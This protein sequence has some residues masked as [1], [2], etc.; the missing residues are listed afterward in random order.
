MSNFG[1]AYNASQPIS[2]AN[3]KFPPE[4]PK[5]MPVFISYPQAGSTLID[6]TTETQMHRISQV[7]GLYIDNTDGPNLILVCDVT[8]QTIH[9]PS[10][11][12]GY[13]QLLTQNPPKFTLTADAA[14][15]K[16]VQLFFLN[17]P[18]VHSVNYLLPPINPGVQSIVAGTNVTVD[19]TDPANPIVSAS[20]GG[21]GGGGKVQYTQIIKPGAGQTISGGDI[22]G[23]AF[24]PFFAATGAALDLDFSTLNGLYLILFQSYNAAGSTLNS[25]GG[26]WIID[27]SGS[28]VGSIATAQ[29]EVL[30][31]MAVGDGAGNSSAQVL[32]RY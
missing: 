5:S 2:T 6:L 15:V 10:N 29:F 27:Q 23:A 13:Y 17:F 18:V 19:N 28:A 22:S 25:V 9:I 7:Q 3:N 30:E 14:T 32:N 31:I 4:G 1:P 16:D 12:Q 26:A 11:A 20:G 24:T 8:E 21:G